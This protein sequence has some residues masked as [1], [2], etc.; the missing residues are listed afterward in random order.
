M[1]LLPVWLLLIILLALGVGLYTSALMVSYRDVQ[2]VLPVV[3]QFLLYASP[4]R[5]CLSACPGEVAGCLR[6]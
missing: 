3:T 5:L 2:Y 4:G 6:A 1:L